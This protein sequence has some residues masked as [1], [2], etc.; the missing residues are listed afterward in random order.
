MATLDEPMSVQRGVMAAYTKLMGRR[1]I[2]D[3]PFSGEVYFIDAITNNPGA[4]GGVITTRRG[5]LLG[6]VG[7]EMRN[8]LTDTWINY[9]IPINARIEVI[10]G[11]DKRYATVTE[12]IEKKEQYKPITTKDKNQK[13]PGTFHG[14][15][16]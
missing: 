11:A 13:G 4:A 16:L 14:I 9:A 1:G 15:I 7:K 8:T 5:E 6:L 3:A 10:N 12:M 2:F